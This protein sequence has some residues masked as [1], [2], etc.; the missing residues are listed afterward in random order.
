MK[1]TQFLV[2]KIAIELRI[3]MGLCGKLTQNL[4]KMRN[5]S[6]YAYTSSLM[7]NFQF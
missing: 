1:T 2:I 5:H 3:L 7:C 6:E 4:K